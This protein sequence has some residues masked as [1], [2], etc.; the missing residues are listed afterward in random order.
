[1]AEESLILELLRQWRRLWAYMN[2]SF[3][4]YWKPERFIGQIFEPLF[5]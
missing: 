3:S 1:M 2:L 4:N 5:S